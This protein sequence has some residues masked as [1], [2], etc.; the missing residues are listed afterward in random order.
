MAKTDR[1]MLA[2]LVTLGKQGELSGSLMMS[3]KNETPPAIPR[4]VHA[5][6][7]HRRWRDFPGTCLNA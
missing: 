7:T 1:A 5:C 3:D 2:R 6:S 4:E